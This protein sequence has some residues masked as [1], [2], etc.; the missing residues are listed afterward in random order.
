MKE[1]VDAAN[2]MA[3]LVDYLDAWDDV[4]DDMPEVYD[5]IRKYAPDRVSR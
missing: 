5:F 1:L 2:L 4:E 3:D